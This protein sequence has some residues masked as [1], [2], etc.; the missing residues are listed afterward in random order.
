MPRLT[1]SV[2]MGVKD[3]DNITVERDVHIPSV[4]EDPK[5]AAELVKLTLEEV[6]GTLN[7]A[8]DNGVTS[9]DIP[10]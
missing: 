4:N 9:G 6:G 2:K 3:G 8:I 1:I 7:G 10:F 5:A